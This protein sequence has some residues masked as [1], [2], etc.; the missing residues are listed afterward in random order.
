MT[1]RDTVN[2]PNLTD[3]E[4]HKRFVDTAK[5]IGASDRSE[6][7]DRAFKSLNIKNPPIKKKQKLD[8]KPEENRY[9]PS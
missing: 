6:D 9:R 1:K 4:R 3:A 5:Q 7:F 8:T 2:K